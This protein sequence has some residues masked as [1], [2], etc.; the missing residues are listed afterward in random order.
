MF[1]PQQAASEL[2]EKMAALPALYP[3]S[4]AAEKKVYMFTPTDAERDL[5]VQALRIRRGFPS[6]QKGMI[7]GQHTRISDHRAAAPIL[8]RQGGVGKTSFA[9]A[10][11]VLLADEE[12]RTPGKHLSGI[13]PRRCFWHEAC[14]S[15]TPVA[16][17]LL[18]AMKSIS[19]PPRSIANG[20]L[21]RTEAY[22]GGKK[23]TLK[24]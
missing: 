9:Y 1:N 20:R 5:I 7:D 23:I 6:E 18:E 11:A 8:H 22:S 17:R 12:A 3:Y 24:G 10:S 21:G 15:S 19:E 4:G 14:N 13:E 2:A 16:G